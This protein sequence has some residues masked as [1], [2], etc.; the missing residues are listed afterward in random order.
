MKNVHP[1]EMIGGIYIGCYKHDQ[2]VVDCAVSRLVYIC[3][4]EGK[5]VAY[6]SNLLSASYD[7]KTIKTFKHIKLLCNPYNNLCCTQEIN[8]DYIN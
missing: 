6:K 1:A 7:G 3:I 4:C 8:M 5:C 2:L